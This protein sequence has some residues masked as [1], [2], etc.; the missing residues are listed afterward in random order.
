MQIC[1]TLRPLC[2]ALLLTRMGEY[3]Y[4]FIVLFS[5][6]GS[7]VDVL[8]LCDDFRVWTV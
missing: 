5:L 4:M 6:V 8:S 2:F 1:C 7:V 3:L